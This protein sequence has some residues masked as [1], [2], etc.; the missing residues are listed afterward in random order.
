MIKNLLSKTFLLLLSASSLSAEVFDG[1]VVLKAEPVVKDFPLYTDQIN[2]NKWIL[3]DFS[4]FVEGMG[5]KVK[6]HYLSAFVG[7]HVELDDANLDSLRAD[8]RV[9]SVSANI[10]VYLRDVANSWG[11]DRVDQRD[12]PLN[13][14]YDIPAGG[15]SVHVYVVD[16]GV[17]TTH[18]EFTNIGDGFSSIANEPSTADC[19]GHGTHVAGTI[20]GKTVGIARQ[21]IIHPVR[22][23][24]CQGSGTLQGI[25]DGLEWVIKNK[26][27]PAVINMSLGGGGNDAFDTATN[28]AI[29]AGITVVVAAGNS[30]DDS[31]KYSP[32]RV[33]GAITVS[34]STK[35]DGQASFSSFGKCVDIYAPGENINSASNKDN[36][37]YVS[38]NGTSM[39]SPHV[40]G[41]A[42][43]ELA[44]SP[45][46]KPQDVSDRLVKN[47]TPNKI[48]NPGA[49]TPNLLLYVQSAPA[50]NLKVS[51]G[52]D[53]LLKPPFTSTTL[54]GTIESS[55]P[56]TYARWKQISGPKL[57]LDLIPQGVEFHLEL[58]DLEAGAYV[59][60]FSA[61]DGTNKA[62]DEVNIT[63]TK[64]NASL[65][66]YVDAGEDKTVKIPVD[67][68]VLDGICRDA[69]GYC[70]DMIWI[71]KKRSIQAENLRGGK[72]VLSNLDVGRYE[73]TLSCTDNDG[74]Q[75][76]DT[77]VVTV[78]N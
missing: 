65:L 12:L 26:K 47:A 73:F 33:P 39:A 18:Q 13:N 11:V 5:G 16:T 42:A 68:L 4:T 49:L 3:D 15:A 72:L 62:S 56:L 6:K 78:T 71:W 27:D 69:D 22:V 64:D 70:Q 53:V 2:S 19:H 58:N 35:T 55:A 48:L 61:S 44:S 1:F 24:N 34:A 63:V 8:E 23:L 67:K 51:A 9:K 74:N 54:V 66:P 76:E 40:A 28:N 52:L 20:A 41:A 17:T 46:L 36:K 30:S 21:S 14:S 43:L 25:I 38:F 31:C 45:T 37:G 60:E 57:S 77:V 29:K 50:S 10:P 59:F 7:L 32:A 75:N